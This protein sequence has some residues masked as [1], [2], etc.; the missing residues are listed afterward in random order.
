MK[1]AIFGHTN[2]LEIKNTSGATVRNKGS[3]GQIIKT[4]S[5]T[6]QIL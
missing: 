2:A 5:R 4:F 1:Q 3:P 6:M